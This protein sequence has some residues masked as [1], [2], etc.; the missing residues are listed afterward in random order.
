LIPYFVSI[1]DVCLGGGVERCDGL[2]AMS[3]DLF[4]P[5]FHRLIVGG[6]IWS[7]GEAWFGPHDHFNGGGLDR[8]ILP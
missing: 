3:F 4:R 1:F 5:F 6:R 8:G 2:S 7:R